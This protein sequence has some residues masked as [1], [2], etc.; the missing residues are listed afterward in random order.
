MSQK[1]GWLNCITSS[2]AEIRCHLQLNDLSL[3]KESLLVTDVLKIMVEYVRVIQS[4]L[5]G[6]NNS[7]VSF[8]SM[9]RPVLLMV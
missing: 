4:F 3:F 5:F 9:K 7:F 8:S 6:E 1:A 2:S